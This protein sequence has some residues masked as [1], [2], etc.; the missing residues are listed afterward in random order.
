MPDCLNHDLSFCDMVRESH[1]SHSGGD[2]QTFLNSGF[3][4]HILIVREYSLFFDV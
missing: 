1:T 3:F 4:F 2:I